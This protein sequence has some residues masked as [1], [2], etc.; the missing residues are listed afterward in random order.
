MRDLQ[1]EVGAEPSHPSGTAA[2]R[3]GLPLPGDPGFG[4]GAGAGHLTRVGRGT[5]VRLALAA[6]LPAQQAQHGQQAG[7]KFQRAAPQGGASCLCLSWWEC[8]LPRAGRAKAEVRVVRELLGRR[9]AGPGGRTQKPEV[10]AWDLAGE[11]WGSGNMVGQVPHSCHL[12]GWAPGWDLGRGS[13][14]E[15]VALSVCS[16]IHLSLQPQPAGLTG[17]LSG[18]RTGSSSVWHPG[19]AP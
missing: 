12:P 9:E 10:P 1:A 3:E 17:S 8:A 5:A 16:S 11:P 4:E 13:G 15:V 18:A 14:A 6:V 19:A 7:L 2:Q